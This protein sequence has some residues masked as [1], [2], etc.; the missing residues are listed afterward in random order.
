MKTNIL[1]PTFVR[2]DDRG[3]FVEFLN[4]YTIENASYGY[5]RKGAIMGN[6]YH[7]KTKVFFFLTSGSAEVKNLYVQTK[8]RESFKLKKNEG[9]VFEPFVTHTI[10]FQE[11]STFILLKTKPYDKKNSDT[12]KHTPNA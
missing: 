10:T 11:D 3:S 12:F 6:H 1:I 5:M 8:K 4:G 7:K 9:T 2:Q